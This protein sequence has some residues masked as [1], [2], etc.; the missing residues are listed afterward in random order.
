MTTDAFAAGLPRSRTQWRPRLRGTTRRFRLEPHSLA[1]RA[2]AA[3]SPK[4]HAVEPAACSTLKAVSDQV[5]ALLAV[6]LLAPLLL[7]I[8]AAVRAESAGP[9]IFRQR[10]HGLGNCEFVVFKFRTMT[11]A[12][13]AAAD[14]GRVQTR[15]GDCRITRVGSF[16]RKTSLDEL[17]Q[18]FNVLNGTMS[19]VGPRPH[20]VAMRTHGQRCE[21]L[22]ANYGQ[23]HQ[24]KPGITGWAQVNGYRGATETVEHL[25]C[26]VEHD[27]YYV[28]HRSFLFDLRILLLTP[29]SILFHRDRAF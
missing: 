22:I 27:I 25:R 2:G 24:V 23:R 9:V 20:P 13:D 16:L 11:W 21:D 4:P 12:P 26:R 19:L 7:A 15:R 8:A 3:A 28:E 18:L 14:D 5:L 17:A 1:F 29:L 6:V 10:R